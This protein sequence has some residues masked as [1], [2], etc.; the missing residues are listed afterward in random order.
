MQ[1]D[2]PAKRD[3]LQCSLLHSD[4]Q[5]TPRP[6]KFS[7]RR[8][9]KFSLWRIGLSVIL[10]AVLGV[11]LSVIAETTP[12]ESNAVSQRRISLIMTAD[13]G[14]MVGLSE[15]RVL[16]DQLEGKWAEAEG[17]FFCDRIIHGTLQGQ[18]VLLVTTGIGH[19]HASV[20]MS[21]LLRA[22]DHSLKD[23]F[24]LGTA[25][26][27]PRRGGILD[28]DACDEPIGGGASDDALVTIGD[29]CVSPFATNW[30]CQRCVWSSEPSS[31]TVC[32]RPLCSV[33]GRE[34]LF[35][36][37]VCTFWGGA[38]STALADEV[39]AASESVE[40]PPFPAALAKHVRA[41]W[42]AMSRGTGRDYTS[43][44]HR[45]GSRDRD[46]SRDATVDGG[47]DLRNRVYG[48]SMCSEA[49]SNT[50]WSGAPYDY[51]AREYVASLT[52]LGIR[53]LGLPSTR[54]LTALDTIAVSAMEG[55]GW[56]SVLMMREM[57]KRGVSIPFV[58]LRGAADYTHAPV[59]P[60]THTL[61][62]ARGGRMLAA[63]HPEW[64]PL[65]IRL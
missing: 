19:D 58:N 43:A 20:C 3:S 6:I 11:S 23:I 54:N 48:Y 62:S 47:S 15:R 32:R 28:P 4:Q 16:E 61:A 49:T 51:L 10:M 52:N 18:P 30:D 12:F 13:P 39:I 60:R 1:L 56:M 64:P 34:D 44:L 53:K 50:F 24:F 5:A 57:Y 55:T 40:M 14:D 27:S 25:G 36:E 65:A 35:G 21:D 2:A 63:S 22:F 33:H 31:G 45:T 9:T 29:V 41:Y 46:A 42:D 17:L 37:L 59:R 26:F 38:A 7:S 8:P